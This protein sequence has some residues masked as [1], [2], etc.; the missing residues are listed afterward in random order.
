[1][2]KA[3]LMVV[4]ERVAPSSRLFMF[5]RLLFEI[6]LIASCQGCR[7][8]QVQ[9]YHNNQAQYKPGCTDGTCQVQWRHGSRYKLR[10]DGEDQDNKR[11]NRQNDV[12]CNIELFPVFT[13]VVEWH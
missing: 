8:A 9:E 1:M 12:P 7:P 2:R 3:C 13:Q 11:Y 5:L 6:D 10:Q 4:T